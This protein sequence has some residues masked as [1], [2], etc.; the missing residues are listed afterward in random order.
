[1]KLSTIAAACA[2][3]FGFVAD[4]TGAA[5][6]TAN[7]T[8]DTDNT[9]TLTEDSTL[10]ADAAISVGTLTV[11]GSGTLTLDGS[12]AVTATSLHIAS[13][14]TVQLATGT[15]LATGALR[16]STVTGAG[17]IGYTGV[18]P[19]KSL[20][21]WADAANWQ[22]TVWA[23]GLTL[24][25]WNPAALGN[26]KSTL[27][28]SGFTGYFASAYIVVPF[29]VELENSTYD[30]AMNVNDGYSYNGNGKAYFATPVLKGAG[31]YQA[32][33]KGGSLFVVTTDW[34]GFT[35]DFALTGKTVWLGYPAPGTSPG[36]AS[37]DV[38][39]FWGTRSGVIRIA[40]GKSVN[41]KSSWSLTDFAGE[42]TIKMAAPWDA[43]PTFQYCVDDPSLWTGTVEL[44][45]CTNDG[46]GSV[47]VY[48]ERMGNA[49]STVV[50]K[51]L[52]PGETKG[53]Y[54][55][56][57]ASLDTTVRLDGD[58]T[59]SDGSSSTTNTIAVLTGIGNFS[60]LVTSS[61]SNMGI[62]ITTLSNYTGI[63]AANNKTRIEVSK[64][65]LTAVP[66]V[67]DRLFKVSSTQG[68]RNVWCTQPTVV[69]DGTEYLCKASLG[70]DGYYLD[71]ISEAGG[72][73]TVATDGQSFSAAG[74][75]T[76]RVDGSAAVTSFTITGTAE[77]VT[78]D[79][80]GVTSP[81]TVVTEMGEGA[82]TI[83]APA[84]W[85]AIYDSTAG[86]WRIRPTAFVIHV[87]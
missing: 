83:V 72:V 19:E 65:A 53:Y 11:T 22:G 16:T 20:A 58:V 55:T 12:A 82:I 50:L 37:N 69:V 47:C 81:V 77:G 59:I 3:V 76:Y 67:G 70:T 15:T 35:G 61:A 2:A 75:A 56:K 46:T 71:E 74:G 48:P 1:M 6:T 43:T 49:A 52:A 39:S 86:Q 24:K 14:A 25:G 26:A 18:E 62:N 5:F 17:V 32:N 85:G 38:D 66:Q 60:A 79:A 63:V 87:R 8:A 68:R 27:R 44:A 7:L 31:K 40:A 30:F 29:A 10:T 57:G 4:A 54:F 23:Q 64:I 28:I 42:G 84:N 34:S 33:D 73:F 13:G 41:W 78:V 45:E 9:I 21:C 51:G 36:Y 80:S